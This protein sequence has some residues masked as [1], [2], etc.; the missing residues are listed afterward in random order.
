MSDIK[1]VSKDFVEVISHEDRTFP[2][3][4]G[5]T[6]SANLSDPAIYERAAADPEAFWAEQA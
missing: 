4:A 2:P 1:D 5:F 6:A 3:P